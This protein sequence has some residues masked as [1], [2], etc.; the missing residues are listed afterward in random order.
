MARLR[1]LIVQSM[2]N[3]AGEDKAFHA[4]D[5]DRG[6]AGGVPGVLHQADAAVSAP[7]ADHPAL[8]PCR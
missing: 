8:K 6:S 2:P 4:M 1:E 7:A 5:R 3:I